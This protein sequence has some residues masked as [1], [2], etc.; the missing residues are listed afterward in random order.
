VAIP[1][2]I[3]YGFTAPRDADVFLNTLDHL[4]RRDPLRRRFGAPDGI[5]P[6]PGEQQKSPA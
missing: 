1:L 6:C 5:K 3:V 4:L 2:T